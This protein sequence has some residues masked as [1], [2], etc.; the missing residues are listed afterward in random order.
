MTE[1]TSVTSALTSAGTSSPPKP[2]KPKSK[3]KKVKRHKPKDPSKTE[4]TKIST[5]GQQRINCLQTVE[6]SLPLST[7]TQQPESSS[8]ANSTVFNSSD[9]KLRPIARSALTISPPN[10][11]MTIVVEETDRLP[12]AHNPA[13]NPVQ[14]WIQFN[15]KK[16]PTFFNQSFYKYSVIL[17]PLEPGESTTCGVEGNLKIAISNETTRTLTFSFH[18]CKIGNICLLRQ[19]T[20]TPTDKSEIGSYS[21]K[22]IQ[23]LDKSKPYNFRFVNAES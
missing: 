15:Q 17:D 8:T 16:I 2:N 11:Q 10:H 4:D 6:H 23:F 7:L 20:F 13:Y 21:F 5:L 12:T 19:Y 9:Q 14:A 3:T 1:T 18:I 22:E